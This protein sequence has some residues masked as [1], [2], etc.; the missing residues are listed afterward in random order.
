VLYPALAKHYNTSTDKVDVTMKYKFGIRSKTDL[1][2]EELVEFVDC[3]K[4]YAL[5]CGCDIR[6]HSS[7]KELVHD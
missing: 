4:A 3:V 2:H 5:V 1:T 6:E 7:S